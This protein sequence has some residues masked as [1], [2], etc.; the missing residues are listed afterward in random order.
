MRLGAT[1]P[2]APSPPRRLSPTAH[3]SVLRRTESPASPG[4]QAS[5][6]T[7]LAP[8]SS[9]KRG[10]GPCRSNQR[11]QDKPGHTP[12]PHPTLHP[13][14]S[15]LGEERSGDGE[16]TAVMSPVTPWT[17]GTGLGPRLAT[18]TKLPRAVASFA[19]RE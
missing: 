15:G 9:A 17:P 3:P 1:M 10:D 6:P 14:T 5:L 16:V 11:A 8:L 18:R 13:E 7:G 4:V 2:S 19:S 12:G